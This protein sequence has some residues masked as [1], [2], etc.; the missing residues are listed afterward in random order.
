MRISARRGASSNGKIV[1]DYKHARAMQRP[2]QAI[3]YRFF[4]WGRPNEGAYVRLVLNLDGPDHCLSRS[5]RRRVTLEQR[6]YVAAQRKVRCAPQDRW[7]FSPALGRSGPGYLPRSDGASSRSDAKW[8][9]GARRISQSRAAFEVR[10]QGAIRWSDLA[11]MRRYV[12]GNG[13]RVA[14]Q[15][16]RQARFLSTACC[17]AP[18]V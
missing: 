15:A 10:E 17:A 12:L 2:C 13:V 9:L 14:R 3:L 11:K 4:A 5:R 1:F 7:I 6:G 18:R 8:E 16:A